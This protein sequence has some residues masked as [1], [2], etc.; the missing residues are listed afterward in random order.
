MRWGEQGRSRTVGLC[1]CGSWGLSWFGH[2]TCEMKAYFRSMVGDPWMQS[3]L[4]GPRPFYIRD[5]SFYA[6][7]YPQGAWNQPHGHRRA[8]VVMS[9]GSQKLNLDFSTARER[10]RYPQSPHCSRV[11]RIEKKEQERS[12]EPANSEVQYWRSRRNTN[13]R[14]GRK[15]YDAS[16]VSTKCF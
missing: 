12:S 15:P 2:S 9:W 6:L 10:G 13:Y 11:N 14:K 8:T 7:W 1:V 3:Q 5:T 16:K 4:D